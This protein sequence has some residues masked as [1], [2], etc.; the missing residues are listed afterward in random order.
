MR[1]T[2]SFSNYKKRAVYRNI[3]IYNK[4][5]RQNPYG[6]N[7]MKQLVKK[8]IKMGCTL[9]PITKNTLKVQI[10]KSPTNQ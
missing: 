8:I 7:R 2:T 6:Q 4:N 3:C 10:Q 9:I 1:Y 5:K